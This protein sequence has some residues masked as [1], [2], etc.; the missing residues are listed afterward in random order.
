MTSPECFDA[1][2]NYHL[3]FRGQH[4]PL[5]QMLDSVLGFEQNLSFDIL[6]PYPLLQI[7][8]FKGIMSTLY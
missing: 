3:D 5:A 2:M 8:C 4:R 6:L 1:I 7:H